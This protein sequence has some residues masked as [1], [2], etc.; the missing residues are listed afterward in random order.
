MIP[1]ETYKGRRK[2]SL[3]Q[4]MQTY[5]LN[6]YNQVVEY[7]KSKFVEPPN[8]K[9]FEEAKNQISLQTSDA[10]PKKIVKTQTSTSTTRK[11]A[12]STRTTRT[13]KKKETADPKEV[14]QDGLDGSYQAKKTPR[15]TR[16][17]RKKAPTR[18]KS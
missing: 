7:F 4:T 14:W 13:T 6:T 8:V 16:T 9:E 15:K 2:I 18:K 12:R 17:T 3:V 11:K 10:Q 1:W 5:N